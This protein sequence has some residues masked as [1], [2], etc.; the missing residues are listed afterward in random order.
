MVKKLDDLLLGDCVSQTRGRL[1]DFGQTREIMDRVRIS[2][3]KRRGE[4]EGA[5]GWRSV[6]PRL[7]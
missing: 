4:G 3:G 1:L 5:D 7:G 2:D 6:D